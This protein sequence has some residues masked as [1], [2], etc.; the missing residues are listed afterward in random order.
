MCAA[1]S[2]DFITFDKIGIEVNLSTSEKKYKDQIF[3]YISKVNDDLKLIK[4]TDFEAETL[5]EY[6]LTLN[7]SNAITTVKTRKDNEAKE[8]AKIKAERTQKRKNDLTKLGLGFVEI[9]NAYEFN[10][11]IYI[12]SSDIEDLLDEDFIKKQS[13]IEVKINNLKSI[14]LTKEPESATIQETPITN[15]PKKVVYTPVSAPT[16]IKE[17]EPLKKASFEVTATMAQ[18]RALGAYMKENNIAYKNI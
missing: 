12:V 11:D 1:E 10:A 5:T 18:L 14:V 9:T 13:E 3:K 8:K 15:P 2:I 4:S 17:S 7:V 16:I 6:K